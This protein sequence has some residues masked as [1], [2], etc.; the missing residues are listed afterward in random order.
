[1]C[2]SDVPGKSLMFGY[3]QSRKA[4]LLTL[5]RESTGMYVRQ[6]ETQARSCQ[7]TSDQKDERASFADECVLPTILV[8]TLP[9]LTSHNSGPD[10]TTSKHWYSS[11]KNLR[12]CQSYQTTAGL[13]I[14]RLK[15][16]SLKPSS[17][18]LH[19]VLRPRTKVRGHS[20]VVLQLRVMRS[21]ISG[22]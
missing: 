19:C 17:R 11:N 14:S 3:R 4:I 8:F 21:S 2:R 13:I 9:H 20:L 12:L 15:G 18:I 1:M 6:K 22:V 16:Q 7:R 5:S 10:Q